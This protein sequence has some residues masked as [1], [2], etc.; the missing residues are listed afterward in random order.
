MNV[1]FYDSNSNSFKSGLLT[2]TNNVYS[3]T[4][5]KD[6]NCD[7][8]FSPGWIDIHTHILDG[9]GLFGT[10]ADNIGYKTGVCLTVDAGTVGEFTLDGFK[11]YIAPT[12]KT[13]YKI[14]LS[15]SPIGVI[16]HHDYNVMNYLNVERTIKV[17]NENRD[18]ISGIKV[19]IGSE[20]IR[21]EGIQP[22]IMASEV[23]KATSLPL[24]VHVGGTPPY[25]E[26]MEPYFKKGDILT[27]AFNGRGNYDIWNPDGTATDTMEKLIE[28]GILIDVGHGSGSFD[29]NVFEK[30]IKHPI[31]KF[32]IGSD[33]HQT[34]IKKNVFNM[35]TLLSKLYGCGISLE[36][37]LYGITTGP[38]SVL[39]LT[40]WCELTNITNGTFFR[41]INKTAEYEDCQNNFRTY[42][43][44]IQPISVILNGKL[45]EF[46]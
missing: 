13:N 35:G 45:I 46:T 43:Q 21:H 26:E 28:K 6:A 11:R 38:A 34:S 44:V 3:I 39:K 23:A 17:V 19:R 20:T 41:I 9:F 7:L 36:N 12:L 31:P 1:K 15:I 30:A 25:L 40:H 37:L 29:F 10:N 16:F 22:L 8:Y 14:F 32:L 24:M 2:N 27:H 33:L 18:C 5:S 4:P 42:K